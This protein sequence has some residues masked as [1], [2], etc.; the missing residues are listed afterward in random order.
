MT[1]SD[2]R[3][4]VNRALREIQAVQSDLPWSCTDRKLFDGSRAARIERTA[5]LADLCASCRV[6][7][8]VT[9]LQR[10]LVDVGEQMR[11]IA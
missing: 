11:S 6:K 1:S 4:A 8:N 10:R 7:V 3:A 5:E 9:G 2:A